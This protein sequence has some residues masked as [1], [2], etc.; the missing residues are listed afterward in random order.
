MAQYYTQAPTLSAKRDTAG[1]LEA[2]IELKRA[3]SINLKTDDTTKEVFVTWQGLGL[4]V[5]TELILVATTIVGIVGQP[6]VTFMGETFTCTMTADDHFNI[7]QLG[8]AD[9]TAVAENASCFFTVAA[10]ANATTYTVSAFVR[11]FY[12]RLV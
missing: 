4:F 2:H 7:F 11:G 3:D 1:F 8:T 5:P 6:Q 12:T 9:K 10:I